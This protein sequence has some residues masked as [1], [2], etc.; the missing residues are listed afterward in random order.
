MFLKASEK[1]FVLMDA[2]PP[3][4][5][6]ISCRESVLLLIAVCDTMNGVAFD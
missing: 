2:R 6:A 5:S 3:V 4:I 1:L